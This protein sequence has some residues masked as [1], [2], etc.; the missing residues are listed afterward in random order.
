[1]QFIDLK[2][3]YQAYKA[4]IDAAMAEVVMSTQFIMG[5]AV[6]EF[7]KEMAAYIG[8]KHA[9]GCTS[10]TDALL[11]AMMALGVR[12]GDEVLVPDFTF[13]ATAEMVSLLGAVPVFVDVDERTYNMD[14]SDLK[15]K[16]TA[17]S[18]GVIPVSLY[19]QCA[20]CEEIPGLWM[21]EDAAQS[22]GAMRG[23]NKSGTLTRVATTSFYPAKPLGC[24]GEGGAVFTN[25][26]ALAS[27]IRCLLNQGQRQQY[28]HARIGI[29]GRLD[30]LQAAVLRVKLRHLDAELAA[31][32]RVA[33]R[34]TAKLEG[35]VVTPF[36]K[37]G[38]R[39][40]WA[41]YTVR[42]A[43]RDEVREH[44]KS[45]GIPTAVHY[46]V[47]LHRQ[48]VFAC[49]GVKDE[50]CPVS[51][52]VSGEVV[53]LPMHPFLTDDEVDQVASALRDVARMPC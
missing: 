41:Q 32:Q 38:N 44:L 31:R 48:E 13:F 2:T 40:V 37:P 20:D 23:R 14:P 34:Y 3:Q 15:R 39:S 6:H 29:N 36:I 42:V 12:P 50:S 11:L 28:Q 35:A 47:P 22:F 26:D 10:G 30:T 4:E 52:K 18:K 51:S 7:E 21:I 24:Y 16:I 43:N 45:K 25:E 19:G 33:E 53:S 5:P 49:L 1:M 17:R 9:I 46:P 27:E 8:V